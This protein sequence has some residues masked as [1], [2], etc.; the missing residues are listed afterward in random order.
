MNGLFYTMIT[1]RFEIFI[2]FLFSISIWANEPNPSLNNEVNY[3]VIINRNNKTS[4]ASVL[5][6]LK[7]LYLRK[8]SEWPNGIKAKPIGRPLD[9]QEHAYFLKLVLGMSEAD[10]AEYWLSLKQRTGQTSPRSVSSNKV[11]LKL[12]SKYKGAFSIV[13]T[14]KL[15]ILPEDLTIITTLT[16]LP[17]GNGK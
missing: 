9:S 6:L 2:F 1:F 7:Q 4:S 10:Y 11:L 12:I 14:K 17:S 5:S 13:D 15:D 3:S 16:E 8:K